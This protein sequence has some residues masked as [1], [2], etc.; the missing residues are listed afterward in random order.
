MHPGK[1]SSM[2]AKALKSRL[3]IGVIVIK[4]CLC[5]QFSPMVGVYLGVPRPGKPC[6]H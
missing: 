3:R 1:G 6:T 2:K 4:I 5:E